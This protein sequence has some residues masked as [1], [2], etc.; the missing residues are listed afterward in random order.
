[1]SAIIRTVAKSVQRLYPEALA[2]KSWDNTGCKSS[3]ALL[4]YSIGCLKAKMGIIVLLEAPYRTDILRPSRKHIVLLTIDVTK[5]VAA[6][7]IEKKAAAIVSYRGSSYPLQSPTDLI[8]SVFILSF[9]MI[10]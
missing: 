2:D 6:E 5:A 9:L 7:A 10:Y 3:I 4:W 8:I 1:M